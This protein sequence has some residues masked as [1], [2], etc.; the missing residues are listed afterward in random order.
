MESR[1][2][3][4]LLAIGANPFGGDDKI[5]GDVH[6]NIE[7]FKAVLASLKPN[8][9]LF[10][11]GDLV[12][13]GQDSLGVIETIIDF[14]QK[15]PDRLFAIRGNHED[16]TLYSIGALEKCG[17]HSEQ[18]DETKLHLVNGGRWLLV[19]L[20]EEVKSGKIKLVNNNFEYASDSKFNKVKHFLG[21]LPYVIH[22]AADKKT[23][24][25]A[26]NIVHA[27]MPLSDNELASKLKKSEFDL[28]K[29]YI[30][31][32]KN[33]QMPLFYYAIWA[34]EKTIESE[35]HI[36]PSHRTPTSSITY[37]GHSITAFSNSFKAVRN[38]T[39]TV[40]LDVG[41]YS[42]ETFLV[43][44]HTKA[45]CEVIC[46]EEYIGQNITPNDVKAKIAVSAMNVAEHLK[47]QPALSAINAIRSYIHAHIHSTHDD[48]DFVKVHTL[49]QAYRNELSKLPVD[50]IRRID[51]NYAKQMTKNNEADIKIREDISLN[52]YKNVKDPAEQKKQIDANKAFLQRLIDARI[53]YDDVKL[54]GELAVVAR[55]RSSPAANTS[56][57]FSISTAD[58][59]PDTLSDKPKE[60]K[61]HH[62]QHKHGH[63]HEHKHH[64]RHRKG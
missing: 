12:D 10:L 30:T 48:L 34:R 40:N 33:Q 41:T 24:A 62:K 19:L 2:N 14:Q 60:P 18:P 5:I 46:P 16:L 43:A 35:V 59:P 47:I 31:D 56:A 49:T 28:T 45:T 63:G 44:N 32:G 52:I 61:P 42:S 27:D 50:T 1:Q 23:G 6:G 39:N 15:N 20:A 22:V 17:L 64:H 54:I 38:D 8:D 57:L 13:R 11:V 4:D 25:P 36:N 3:V 37:V 51:N 53:I 26:F 29:T 7:A 21:D 58:T 9:R 55:L